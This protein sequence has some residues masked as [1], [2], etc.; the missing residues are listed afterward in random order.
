[1]KSYIMCLLWVCLTVFPSALPAQDGSAQD[2]AAWYI[3]NTAVLE[4]E[5]PIYQVDLGLR[6][7]R[8]LPVFGVGHVTLRGT[9]PAQCFGFGGDY[10]PELASDS[11]DAYRYSATLTDGPDEMDWQLNL[12]YDGVPDSAWVTDTTGTHGIT[13]WFSLR[14]DTGRVYLTLS[15]LQQTFASDAKIRVP[16]AYDTTGVSIFLGNTGV[17]ETPRNPAEYELTPAYPNPFNSGTWIRYALPAGN[18]VRLQVLSARGRLV[19]VLEDGPKQAGEH[20]VFW[21]GTDRRGNPAA[22]GVYLLVFRAGPFRRTAKIT[23]LR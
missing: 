10:Q 9:I 14:E 20:T 4:R 3:R 12:V 19:A 18:R 2:S 1:M 7:G 23:L 13:V 5:P 22:S 8:V 16:V 6:A 17:N 15:D 21:D 11:S